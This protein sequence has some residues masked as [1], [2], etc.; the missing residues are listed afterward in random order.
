MK[1][2]NFK[3]IVSTVR[4]LKNQKNPE[5]SGNRLA[6]SDVEYSNDLS[7]HLKT[8]FEQYP[9]QL[10]HFYIDDEV[11]DSTF[12]PNWLKADF[13]I[14]FHSSKGQ[15]LFKELGNFFH[16]SGVTKGIIPDYYYIFDL[17]FASFETPCTHQLTTYFTIKKFSDSLKE[18]CHYSGRN[19]E[20]ELVFIHPDH[21]SGKKPTII[22][23]EI[24]EDLINKT[25]D[26]NLNIIQ[27][28]VDGS[29]Q[30]N[31]HYNAERG[32]FEA[33]LSEF[34]DGK[35][36]P[37]EVFTTL[38]E[39]WEKFNQLYQN[40]LKTYLSGFGFHKARKEVAE[41]EMELAE[42]FSK[43]LGDIGGKLLALPVSLALIKLVATPDI[44]MIKVALCVALI[45]TSI[46]LFGLVQNQE[47][48]FKRVRHAK[49]IT[50]K[51]LE[52]KQDLYPHDLQQDIVEIKNNLDEEE[53]RVKNI[54]TF[55]KIITLAP[56]LFAGI[57]Y[58][59][60]ATEFIK[61]LVSW[62]ASVCCWVR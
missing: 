24:T 60:G 54:L 53:K 62:L 11:V 9:E 35:I 4:V 8:L 6:Y 26:L 18:L 38:I 30:E 58:I 56:I 16:N 19:G 55:L 49:K 47:R 39:G 40:N 27:S 20:N 1:K 22:E 13:N 2:A 52:G 10:Q 59:P 34:A 21:A 44:I 45:V 23:P 28:L 5:I 33:T 15:L 61:T 57:A 12:P 36:Y 31:P 42:K 29:S 50:F 25:E 17:D 14:V 3:H 48:Y 7:Q 41:A 43:V 51:S 37:N 46:F 32:V